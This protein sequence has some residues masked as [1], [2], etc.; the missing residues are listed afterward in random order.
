MYFKFP[1]TSSGYL[2]IYYMERVY[3]R[4]L[5][6]MLLQSTLLE[7]NCPLQ[8]CVHKNRLLELHIEEDK[9]ISEI[10]IEFCHC[11]LSIEAVDRHD[12]L[13]LFLFF[14]CVGWIEGAH[15]VRSHGGLHL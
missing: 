2:L 13:T 14:S 5:Y 6:S 10:Q 4:L 8:S 3:T 9:F 1:L 15:H 11:V 7:F 12:V